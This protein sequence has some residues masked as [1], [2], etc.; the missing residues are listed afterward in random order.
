MNGAEHFGELR[1]VAVALAVSE[2]PTVVPGGGSLP[3]TAAIPASLSGRRSGLTRMGTFEAGQSKRSASYASLCCVG[4]IFP[5]IK[6]RG[7]Q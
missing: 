3:E 6:G 4:K 2:S 5:T 1:G 7:E